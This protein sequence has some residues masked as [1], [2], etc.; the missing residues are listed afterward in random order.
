MKNKKAMAINTIV[1]LVIAL[2]VLLVVLFIFRDQIGKAIGGYTKIS[3]EAEE[4]IEGVR[5]ETLLGERKCMKSC[6]GV[7]EIDPPS[8]K[9][10]K[11]CPEGY[12]CCE[13][14]Q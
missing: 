5:C 6:E 12:K 3:E 10:W 11:D 9:I 2:V 4:T 8:E 1:M 7:K 13:V 14:I